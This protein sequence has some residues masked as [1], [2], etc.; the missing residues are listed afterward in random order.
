[1]GRVIKTAIITAV[2]VGATVATG[3]A[4]G[5][6]PAAGF[7]AGTA[8][9][10]SAALTATLSAMAMAGLGT[11]AMAG[12]GMLTSKGIEATRDNFGTKVSARGASNPRLLIYGECRVGGTITQ[13]QTT[14]TNNTKLCMFIAVAGHIVNKIVRVRFN[15]TI[16]T[17]SETIAN[18]TTINATNSAF[19]NTN[20]DNNMGSGRLVR[21]VAFDGSQTARCTLAASSLGDSFVPTTH[22]FINVAY[23]YFELIFVGS[24]LYMS[25]YF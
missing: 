20:N 8:A 17:H 22:K 19:I 23:V 1:M 13:M 21:F 6:G 12:V 5:F 24:F 3:G 7:A 10:T 16:I 18:D 2:V 15:D 9:G 4:L 14:G 11:L 25:F